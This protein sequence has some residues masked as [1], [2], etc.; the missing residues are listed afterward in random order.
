M[1][2]RPPRSTLFPYTTLFRSSCQGSSHFHAVQR[3]ENG[4]DFFAFCGIEWGKRLGHELGAEAALRAGAFKPLDHASRAAAHSVDPAELKQLPLKL[5]FAGCVTV[6]GS[7][8]QIGEEPGMK[9]RAG[10]DATIPAGVN[11][12]A[13]M[14][15]EAY[16]N[17][18]IR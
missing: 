7:L 11:R 6:F 16:K 4:R 10:I 14:M 15:I 12:L 17:R 1:I 18:P 8:I 3:F 13:E 9:I 2:R 5:L